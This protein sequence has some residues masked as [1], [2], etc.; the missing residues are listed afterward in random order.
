MLSPS[1]NFQFPV[2]FVVIPSK[3]TQFLSRGRKDNIRK[4]S[5]NPFLVSH[6]F[7]RLVKKAQNQ[8]QSA[9]SSPCPSKRPPSSYKSRSLEQEKQ[10]LIKPFLGYL[11]VRPLVQVTTG[12]MLCLITEFLSRFFRM[13]KN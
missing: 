9:K 5:F 7:F 10:N 11:T 8:S 3:P 1:S 2:L 12:E 6:I 4:L 13:A